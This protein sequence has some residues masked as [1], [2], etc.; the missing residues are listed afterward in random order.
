VPPKVPT[1]S[2]PA[3]AK[4]KPP[5]KY[6][7]TPLKGMYKGEHLK[8]NPIWPGDVVEYLDA[9]A[10]QAYKLHVKGGKLYDSA[11][12][13]FDTSV[14][15]APNRASGGSAIFVMDENGDFY[16][17][18]TQIVGKFHHSSLLAGAPVAA[19]GTIEVINGQIRGLSDRSGHYRPANEFTRQAVDSLQRQGVD[20]SALKLEMF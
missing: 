15:K 17:S 4:P 6:K 5:P 2:P 12:N 8:G 11:G 7:T 16:A 1:P 9:N 10:R 13:L 20:T 19:A 3:A 18:K 14:V